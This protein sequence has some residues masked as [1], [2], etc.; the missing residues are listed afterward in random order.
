MAPTSSELGQP[1]FIRSLDYFHS[2][3]VDGQH[4]LS[5]TASPQVLQQVVDDYVVHEPQVGLVADDHEPPLLEDRVSLHTTNDSYVG[6]EEQSEADLTFTKEELIVEHHSIKNSVTLI[7][8]VGDCNPAFVVKELVAVKKRLSLIEKFIKLQNDDMSEDSVA[9]ELESAYAKFVNLLNFFQH[10]VGF[11]F[12]NP[13]NVSLEDMVTTVE[14]DID[15]VA[16]ESDIGEQGLTSLDL[17]EEEN[18]VDHKIQEYI[19]TD[20]HVDQ[21]PSKEPCE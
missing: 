4:N 1:W 9:K 19:F 10:N 6:L 2:P 13:E 8:G 3:L 20:V 18:F 17:H 7:E 16:L 5:I 21:T 14:E 15:Q 11:E 12:D